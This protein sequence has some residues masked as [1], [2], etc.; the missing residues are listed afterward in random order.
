MDQL[1]PKLSFDLPDV[2]GL[3]SNHFCTAQGNDGASRKLR[4]LSYACG[5]VQMTDCQQS[6]F[7]GDMRRLHTADE[8]SS[9]TSDVI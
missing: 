3:R 6:K 2:S 9:Q 4:S 1:F 7:Y 5:K 8:A